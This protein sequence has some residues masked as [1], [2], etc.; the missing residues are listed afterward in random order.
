MVSFFFC[1]YDDQES[2]KART[3]VGSIARQLASN[4]PR[5]AFTKLEHSEPDTT[6]ITTFLQAK[7]GER[8]RHFILL[9]GLDDCEET[10]AKEVVDFFQKLVES[11]LQVKVYCSSR[12]I[13]WLPL[14]FRPQQ[15][16]NLDSDENRNKLA[17]DINHF[18]QISLE[19]RLEGEVPELVIDDPTLILDIR[20]RLQAEAQGMYTSPFPQM[21]QSS[22]HL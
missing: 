2:L 1:R 12:P 10:H 6:A 19:E 15:H 3:I 21:I 13:S 22:S 5:D 7:L 4:L 11:P 14:K 20:D 8:R 17:L 18:I 16:I 9:D